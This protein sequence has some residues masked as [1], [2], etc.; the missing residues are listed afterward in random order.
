M[1]DEIKTSEKQFKILEKDLNGYYLPTNP[2]C[3]SITAVFAA[4]CCVLTML[5]PIPIFGLGFLNIGDIGVMITGFLFGPIIGFLGGGIGSGLADI[6]LAYP[7]TAPF[8]F[9]IKGLEGLLVGLI[10]NPRK[11]YSKLDFRIILAPIIGGLTMVFGY[12]FTELL[13]FQD[14]GWAFGELPGNLILQF[15]LGATASILFTITARKNI[16]DNLPQVF[17]KLYIINTD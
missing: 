15:G 1:N 6:F 14:P 2:L 16:I 4:L 7:E 3:L 9:L 12:F 10:S 17:E 13:I 11:F 5:F 8:T